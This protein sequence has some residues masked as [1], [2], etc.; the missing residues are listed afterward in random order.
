MVSSDRLLSIFEQLFFGGPLLTSEKVKYL[1]GGSRQ[2]EAQVKSYSTADNR[3]KAESKSS[4]I[5]LESLS[6]H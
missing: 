4:S 2:K 6:K 5:P 3:A 1:E